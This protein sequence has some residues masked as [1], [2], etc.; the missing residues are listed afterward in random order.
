MKKGFLL[1]AAERSTQQAL[2]NLYLSETKDSTLITGFS[3]VLRTYE[4]ELMC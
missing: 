2:C 4:N 3:N 1:N